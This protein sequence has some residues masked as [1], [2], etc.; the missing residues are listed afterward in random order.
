MKAFDL[1]SGR[2][3]CLCQICEH[4]FAELHAEVE[5]LKLALEGVVFGIQ[6]LADPKPAVLKLAR[7]ALGLPT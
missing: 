2:A 3:T 4:D 1:G 7:A 6:T 5:R